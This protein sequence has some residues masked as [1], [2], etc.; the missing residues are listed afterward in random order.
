MCNSLNLIFYIMIK[1]GG[2]IINKA[3]KKDTYVE[4]I[5]K[6]INEIINTFINQKKDFSETEK[7][8]DKENDM[9]KD[10]LMSLY[11]T[12][13]R[14]SCSDG[15]FNFQRSLTQEQVDVIFD[16]I[17]E[18]LNEKNSHI[19]SS[20]LFEFFTTSLKNNSSDKLEK[21]TPS[22]LF[23]KAF[24]NNLK[25]E[26]GIN[27]DFLQNITCWAQNIHMVDP[28]VLFELLLNIITHPEKV[29]I[30]SRYTFIMGVGLSPNLVEK[31]DREYDKLNDTP[32]K[33]KS[34]EILRNLINLRNHAG[35]GD[36]ANIA[37]NIAEDKQKKEN[38]YFLKST[39]DQ[40]VSVDFFEK[41]EKRLN[42]VNK[43]SDI[44]KE[45]GPDP[46]IIKNTL[47]ANKYFEND[48]RT[49]SVYSKI[50]NDI[51]VIYNEAFEVD[52]FFDL[53]TKDHIVLKD[54]LEKEGFFQK[55]N[56]SKNLEDIDLM[57][58]TLVSLPL[59]DKVEK[60]FNINFSDFSIREQIQ[61]L[62]FISSKNIGEVEVAKKFVLDG[63]NKENINNRFTSF[64]SL[65]SDGGMGD[66]IIKIGNYFD[67]EKIANDIFCKYAE[68]VRKLNSNVD[69]L[70]SLYQKIF[71]DKNIDKNK[72][73]NILSDRANQLLISAYETIENLSQEEAEK[74]VKKLLKQLDDEVVNK[75][76]NINE[77]KA[78]AESLNSVYPEVL[79]SSIAPEYVISDSQ[80]ENS[81]NS[82]DKE[83]VEKIKADYDQHK[84]FSSERIRE[85]IDF[86]QQ[87]SETEDD[88]SEEKNRYEEAMV[89]LKKVLPL[90][91]SLENKLDQVVYGYDLAKLPKDFNNFENKENLSE[92]IPEKA[93]LFFPVGI[94]KDLPSWEKVL[95]GEKQFAKPIDIYGYM[96]W[97]NNQNRE[98]S[99]VV[100]DEIQVNNYQIRYN[101]SKEE[102]KD[103][104]IK[105]GN[106]EAEKYQKIIDTFSLD[107]IKV[108][109]YNNFINSNK[110]KFDHYE[111]IVGQL[112]NHP[113]F[114]E[115][116]L[117]MVQESVSGAEK[118]EYL[119]YANEE[120]SWILSTNGTKIGHLN[121]ARYDILAALIKNVESA[122]EKMGI[123]AFSNLD[124]QQV[125]SIIQAVS[126]NLKDIINEEKSKLDKKSSPFLYFQRLQDHLNKINIDRKVEASKE[127]KKSDMIL[128]FSCPDVGSA[129]FGWRGVDEKK[130]STIKFKEPYSTY[131]YESHQDL[132]IDSD[133]VVALGDGYI[134][135]KIM[136]L[137]SAKQIDYAEKVI[138]PMLKH[139]LAVLDKAPSSYFEKIGKD[140]DEILEELQKNQSLL[141]TL[142]FIQKYIIKPTE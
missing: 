8:L 33:L 89:K 44:N 45:D 11:K 62:S 60:D 134:S 31:L 122:S 135:G 104:T 115:M 131:F 100:C 17:N 137:E 58:K 91:I 97:L 9:F 110:E 39:L 55:Y 129:S 14:E 69:D 36:S 130:E 136:T 140:K 25:S 105:I 26:K 77:L 119:G 138:K 5:R 117:A 67:N 88:G 75:L 64:L 124:N 12:S 101:K 34:L 2:M 49:K 37:I 51:G 86:Y 90:Q 38:N 50:N 93:P 3:E 23:A 142:K 13:F 42:L 1:E 92:K 35:F 47:Q 99:L 52:S 7:N 76:K 32:L 108:I 66:R 132:L 80:I 133:Q 84:K 74:E 22:D 82:Y 109:R 102:A 94:S 28:D 46:L 125:L 126:K 30:S 128:N 123:D 96:F 72:I 56:K 139:Y 43:Y 113:I 85:I 121:E 53:K 81:Y 59:R 87:L 106:K 73:I 20:F 16:I 10:F 40:I 71:F 6:E 54:I 141:D 118:S 61:F 24:S 57:Y 27:I 111:K 95:A 114:R 68:F 70:G 18:N 107:N 65:E 79:K 83:T 19:M 21:N 116:F 63:K 4:D 78:I 48:R 41:K 112:Q 127:V 15:G 98:I 29:S 120:L 103:L